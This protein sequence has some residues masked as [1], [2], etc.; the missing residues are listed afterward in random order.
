MFLERQVSNT[1]GVVVRSRLGTDDTPGRFDSGGLQS[2][3]LVRRSWLTLLPDDDFPSSWP[4]SNFSI[5]LQ[6]IMGK[7]MM[8]KLDDS[9]KNAIRKDELD[10]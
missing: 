4:L 9:R 7:I 10:R 1:Q 8:E 3:H 5:I 2:R 6:E